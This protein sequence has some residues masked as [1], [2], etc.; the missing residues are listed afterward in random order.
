MMEIL[1][2]TCDK[3]L[4]AI[5]PFAYQ[6]G[7]YWPHHPP[8]IVGGFTKP[9]YTMPDNFSFVSIGKQGDYPVEKWSDGLARLLLMT[10]AD[11]CLLFLEDMWLVQPVKTGIVHMAQDYMYQFEY[12]ARFD[13][14]ADRQFAA[15]SQP[16]DKLAEYDIIISDRQ[17]QYHLSMM[18][19]FWRKE[20]LLRALR[21]NETPWET[22]LDGTPRLSAMMDTIVLGTN[23]CPIKVTLAYRSGNPT[24]FVGDGLG[25]EDMDELKEKGLV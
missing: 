15:G 21:P 11:V 16:Y 19:A 1:V 2:L 14:T 4:H 23:E 6:M 3:Y 22:E 12:V 25:K 13:M 17:S 7:K 24:S 10:E 8:V 18:P 20:H 9:D 5:P